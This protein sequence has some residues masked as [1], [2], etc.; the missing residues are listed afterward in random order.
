[1]NVYFKPK[2]DWKSAS[3]AEATPEAM[4]PSEAEPKP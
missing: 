1:V 2:P 4:P 3:E